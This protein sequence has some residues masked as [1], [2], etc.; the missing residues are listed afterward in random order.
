[1]KWASA[2]LKKHKASKLEEKLERPE[3]GN[4]V[5]H[6]KLFSGGIK[7]EAFSLARLWRKSPE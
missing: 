7:Q 4:Y 6:E 1:M 2:E 3:F 5:N